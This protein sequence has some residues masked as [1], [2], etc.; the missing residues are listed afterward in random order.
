M[1]R[2]VA[3]GPRAGSDA[4]QEVRNYWRALDRVDELAEAERSITEAVLRELHRTVIVRG[5]GRRGHQSQYRDSECPVVDTVTRRI[6][7]AP[8]TPA[9]VPGLVGE[10]VEWLDSRPAQAL[11]APLRAGIASHRFISIHPFPDGN[12]RTGRLLATAELWRAG[13]RM[14]GFLSF[15]EYFNSD[16]ERYYDSIQMGLPVD[17]YE[18]RNDPDHSIWLEYFVGIRAQA[19][20]SLRIRAIQV[21]QEGRFALPWDELHRLQQQVLTRTLSRLLEGSTEACD[22]QAADLVDWFGVSDRTAREWLA[23]WAQA[24]F[25]LPVHTGQGLRVRRYRLAQMWSTLLERVAHLASRE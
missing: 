20:D 11:P 4:E 18:G 2:A 24:G 14:R 25:V 21:H 17:F 8:P 5:P 6:D 19:A 23:E 15:E 12:G 9:D 16:R 10:L 22:I 7:D 1:S 3:L 13:Y